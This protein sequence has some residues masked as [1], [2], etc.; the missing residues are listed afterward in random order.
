M[1][2]I[3]IDVVVL[4]V[5]VFVVLAL[6]PGHGVWGYLIGIGGAAVLGAIAGIVGDAIRRS[7]VSGHT[8]GAAGDSACLRE[9][10]LAGLTSSP[11]V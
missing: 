2:P 8:V 6:A 5:A 9:R 3:R 7:T 1:I 11:E 4:V 10:A